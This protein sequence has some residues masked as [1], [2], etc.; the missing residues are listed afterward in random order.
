MIRRVASF[1]QNAEP[2]LILSSILESNSVDLYGRL[3]I[4]SNSDVG[5]DE[6]A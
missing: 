6:C 5:F 2:T 4:S 1:A 3:G